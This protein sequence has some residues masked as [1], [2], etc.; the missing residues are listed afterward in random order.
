MLEK[1]RTPNDPKPN[2]PDQANIDPTANS[3]VIKKLCQDQVLIRLK[4][5][6]SNLLL[7]K[8]RLKKQVQLMVVLMEFPKLLNMIEK[9]QLL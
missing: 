9:L 1:L 3:L 2:N 6:L 4:I 8:R 5:S 7:K